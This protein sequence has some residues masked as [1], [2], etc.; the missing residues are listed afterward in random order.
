MPRI[1]ILGLAIGWNVGE[2]VFRR[3]VT[4]W[5]GAWT[6]SEFDW[7]YLC[8]A[9]DSNASLLLAFAAFFFAEMAIAPKRNPYS[10]SQQPL[11]FAIMVWALIPFALS[12]VNEWVALLGKAA[13]GAVASYIS[14]QHL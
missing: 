2:G 7:T 6:Q 12:F 1:R 13:V 4:F 10:S 3:L 5:R 9:F 14:W 11:F 8:S